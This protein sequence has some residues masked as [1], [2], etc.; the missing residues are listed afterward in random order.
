[1]I[2][3]VSSD[4]SEKG[5]PRR[6]RAK[7]PKKTTEEELDEQYKKKIT[8]AIEA[9]LKDYAKR[10]SLSQRQVSTIISFVEEHL[11]C[12]VMLGYTFEGEPLTI[13]NA[14]TSK[15]ADSLAHLLQ[16]FVSRYTEGPPQPPSSL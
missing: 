3:M 9:N 7:K 2:R 13:L 11:S 10:K 5:P 12:F 4:D 14:P 15:D 1:M 8:A 6:K 16:K